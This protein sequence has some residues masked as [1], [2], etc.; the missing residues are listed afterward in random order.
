MPLKFWISYLKKN[1]QHCRKFYHLP[2]DNHCYHILLN[3]IDKDCIYSAVYTQII[4]RT[5][6]CF[7]KWGIWN[8]SSCNVVE[9]RLKVE[10]LTDV[11]T[12]LSVCRSVYVQSQIC[13]SKTTGK[14]KDR[15][16]GDPKCGTLTGGWWGRQ[17][18]KGGHEQRRWRFIEYTTR[19]QW[20]GREEAVGGGCF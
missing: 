13:K 4:P 1:K 9:L 19:E 18:C 11:K 16:D 2:I 7:E 10:G 12:C 15:W 14:L 6:H 5:A 3:F 8:Q 20:A 17:W